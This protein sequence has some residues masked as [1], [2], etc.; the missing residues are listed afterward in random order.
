MTSKEYLNQ[1]Y[2]LEQRI[3][4]HKERLDE[5]RKLAGSPGSPGFEEHYNPNR[6]TEAPFIKT[7]YKIM[8]LEEKVEGELQLLLTLQEEVQETIDC[9]PD[10]DERLVLTYRY[11]KNMSWSQIGDELYVDERTVRRW[12]NRALS[13]VRIPENPTIL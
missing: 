10:M 8:D 1:A 5:L 13:H 3:R 4:L 7:L 11:L 2:R 9:L 12:H 6:P